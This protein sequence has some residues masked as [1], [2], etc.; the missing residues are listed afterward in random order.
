MGQDIF[1]PDMWLVKLTWKCLPHSLLS[2]TLST[3]FPNYII[4]DTVEDLS[5]HLHGLAAQLFTNDQQT[6]F[7]MNFHSNC[8][9]I[10]VSGL[11]F[12][13][14]TDWTAACSLVTD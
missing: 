7:P 1:L 2:Q 5:N 8:L 14:L 4:S 6:D 11:L 3:L 13:Y 12:G 10:P 9:Y